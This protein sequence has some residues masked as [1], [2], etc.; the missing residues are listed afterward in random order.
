MMCD[1]SIVGDRE[2]MKLSFALS[3]EEAGPYPV[4]SETLW[5]VVTEGNYRIK[6]APF[7]LEGISFDDVVAVARV[8]D[9][10]YRISYIVEASRNS[11]LWIS[12][13]DA[14][15]GRVVI[16]AL[17]SL[18]CGVEGGVFH[19]YYAVN[20]PERLRISDVYAVLDPAIERKWLLVDYPSVRHE[21]SAAE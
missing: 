2:A 4:S 12:V 9:C 6:N 1:E 21:E 13:Q 18:G 14:E 3:E 7:F 11:T 8:D 10:L 16:D 17:N 20:V 15:H 19:N 5:C